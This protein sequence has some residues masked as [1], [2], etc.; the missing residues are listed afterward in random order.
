LKARKTIRLTKRTGV[1]QKSKWGMERG[2]VGI[3]IANMEKGKKA[4]GEKLH[5]DITYRRTDGREVMGDNMSGKTRGM[6]KKGRKMN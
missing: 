4:R 2:K 5:Q 3:N 6:V 1:T